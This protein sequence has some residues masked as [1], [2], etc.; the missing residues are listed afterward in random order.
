MMG[1]VVVRK[2]F[3]CDGDVAVIQRGL[4]NHDNVAAI[5]VDL[6]RP[7]FA[8]RERA[9]SYVVLDGRCRKG[10]MHDALGTFARERPQI[11]FLIPSAG[12]SMADITS[13]EIL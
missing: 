8:Q 10:S 2:L 9:Q 3:L 7:G 6:S 4:Q 13:L 12:L 1:Y 5:L 11:A